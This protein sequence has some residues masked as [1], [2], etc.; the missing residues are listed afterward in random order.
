[1]LNSGKV[2]FSEVVPSVQRCVVDLKRAHPNV[3]LVVGM[4]HH[5]EV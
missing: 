3:D 1:M 5:G 4:S 2:T